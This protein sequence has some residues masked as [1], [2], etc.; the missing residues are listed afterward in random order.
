MKKLKDN[1]LMLENMTVEK[2]R[3]IYSP[4]IQGPFETFVIFCPVLQACFLRK[5]KFMYDRPFEPQTWAGIVRQCSVQ[6]L[7]K[8]AAI[9]R[10]YLVFLPRKNAC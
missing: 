8:F 2:S 9:S 7:A 3:K 1:T 10:V 4:F 5:H 6:F